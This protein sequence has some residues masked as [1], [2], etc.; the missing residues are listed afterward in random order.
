[1]RVQPPFQPPRA[2]ISAKNDRSGCW[3]RLVKNTTDAMPSSAASSA[4]ARASSSESAT[5]LSSSRCLPTA[6]AS[7][8]IDACTFGGTANATASTDSSNSA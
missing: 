5:G 3:N 8:A 1:M 4:S 7:S 2:W 6:A